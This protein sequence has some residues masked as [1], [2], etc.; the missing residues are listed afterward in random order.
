VKLDKVGSRLI[1]ADQLR[2]RL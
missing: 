2:G 1:F